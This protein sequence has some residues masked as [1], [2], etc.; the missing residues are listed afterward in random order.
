[1]NGNWCDCIVAGRLRLGPTFCKNTK[2][3]ASSC[4]YPIFC[5]FKAFFVFFRVA[6]R[7]YLSGEIEEEGAL[8]PSFFA[9]KALTG[10]SPVFSVLMRATSAIRT[11]CFLIENR[12]NLSVCG[13]VLIYSAFFEKYWSKNSNGFVTDDRLF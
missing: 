6:L 12:I 8:S 1:M 9:D 4:D 2:K 3:M 7:A 5:D 11:G 10:L 13:S